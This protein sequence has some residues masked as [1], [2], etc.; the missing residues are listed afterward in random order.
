MRL[1]RED[2]DY[3]ELLTKQREQFDALVA[4]Y[5]ELKDKWKKDD[6]SK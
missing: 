5:Y 4:K 6:E 2:P 3:Q 1:N